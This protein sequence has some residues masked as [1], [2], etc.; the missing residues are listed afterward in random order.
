MSGV[1]AVAH[2]PSVTPPE[3]TWFHFVWLLTQRTHFPIPDW[4][5][6]CWLVIIILAI[7]AW[8]T[9][10]Q[11]QLFP[12]STNQN[13]AELFVEG[14]QN[15]SV[16]IIGSKGVKYAP[17]I[18]TLFIYILILNLLGIIPGLMSPTAH[19]YVTIGLAIAALLSVHIIAI[20]ENG[21]KGYLS[22]YIDKPLL[23]NPLTAW[24]LPITIL[25]HIIGELAKVMSLSMR[26]FGNIFGEDVVIY[27]FALLG[28]A[29]FGALRRYIGLPSPFEVLFPFQIPI[30][31]LHVLISI[32]Q[33]FVF[34]ILTSV[35]IMMFLEHEE[36]E[37]NH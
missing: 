11:L 24:M 5:L 30:V 36:H 34:A 16:S 37:P 33:A 15:L 25:I 23:G 31:L 19:P 13:I 6:L 10:R 14:I 20:R 21:F 1:E 7:W 26:L 32:V 27:Q 12:T 22:H 4:L 9:R 35:Y 3:E 29:V 28:L 17:L 18:G 2:E 8:W